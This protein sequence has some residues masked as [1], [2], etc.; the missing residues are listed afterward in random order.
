MTLALAAIAELM[1]S[2]VVAVRP[3]AVRADG[4]IT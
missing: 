1:I 3:A 2:L 4:S